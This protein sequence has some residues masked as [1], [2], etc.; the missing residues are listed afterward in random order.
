MWV[1]IDEVSFASDRA[2]EVINNFRNSAVA[3]HRG[4]GY[5]GFRLL[6]DRAQDRALNVSYWQTE[7]DARAD[8]LE[9]SMNP[10]EAG[11]TTT[12][13]TSH[14]YALAIDAV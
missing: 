2:D 5:L 3:L 9:P 10:S 1:R 12:L 14:V 8:R 6:V 11:A 13:V 4:E 7:N